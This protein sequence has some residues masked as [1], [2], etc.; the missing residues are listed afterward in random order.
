MCYLLFIT[1]Y[2]KFELH[3]LILS[4]LTRH[5]KASIY[6]SP[7]T[8]NYWQYSAHTEL[9]RAEQYTPFPTVVSVFFP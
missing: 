2:V 6:V 8:L 3:I 9:M 4:G 5:Y 7:S 1:Q